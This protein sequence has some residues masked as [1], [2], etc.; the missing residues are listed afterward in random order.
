VV[1]GAFTIWSCILSLHLIYKHSRNYTRPQLQRCIIRI[2]FMVPI[3]SID[4]FLSL[5]FKDDAIVFN[6]LRDCYE[7]YVIYI[8]FTYLVCFLS[9]EQS[10]E[11]ILEKK[12]PMKHPFPTC[13]FPKFKPGVSF[14]RWCKFCILQF[15]I[16][17]P[18]IT[19]LALL[20]EMND[21]YVEGDFSP[22][23]GYLYLMILDNLSITVSMYFLVLFYMATKEELAPLKPVPKFLCIKAIIFFS[24]WQS[25]VIAG[26]EKIGIIRSKET[27]TADNIAVGTQDFLIC[28]EMFVV[29]LLH[30]WVFGYEPYRRVDKLPFVRAIMSGKIKE[31]MV[32]LLTNIA[33]TMHPKY[34]F[35]NTR[36]TFSGTGEEVLSISFEVKEKIADALIPRRKTTMF[37]NTKG[38]LPN[39][40]KE[41]SAPLV[42]I[43]DT[44]SEASS[45]QIVMESVTVEPFRMSTDFILLQDQTTD[46]I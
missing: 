40:H 17:K 8:F 20:L 33:D 6:L 32:P 28:L 25:V 23:T 42:Q 16:M 14:L 2:L 30:T 12:P 36:E 10:L 1:S 43:S 24:F 19:T 29:S 38:P 35:Q 7:A 15:T 11:E 37:Q 4:S 18:L 41:E 5:L 46:K 39:S 26:T 9:G 27:W 22:R 44:N 13:F 21:L 31:T 34:D 3:Y 45:P